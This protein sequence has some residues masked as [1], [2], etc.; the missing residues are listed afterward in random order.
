M[1]QVL[2]NLL[3]NAARYTPATRR[4]ASP[5]RNAGRARSPSPS[6][7]A[8]RACRP[9]A[10]GRL[11]DK[12]Y[13]VPRVGEGAPRHRHRPDGGARPGGGHGRL[14]RRARAARSAAWRSTWICP[15]T[16]RRKSG[17][18]PSR[19]PRARDA[20][21]A[22]DGAGCLPPKPSTGPA[23]PGQRRH[24]PS[25]LLVEDDA[26]TR[27]QVATHLR[28]H[29]Y[30][31]NEAHD[32]RAALR[33][34]GA[35]TAGPGGA[36]PRPAGPGRDARHPQASRRGGHADPDPLG[37]RPGGGQGG[38]PGAW[39]GRLP[40]EALRHGRAAGAHPGTPAARRRGP[41]CSTTGS[42][43]SAS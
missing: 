37:A 20:W 27:S 38:G 40:G 4:S 3:E 15:R 2:T 28:G 22:T 14:G 26:E 8:V 18:T 29:G 1:D 19:E 5:P 42:C 17:R 10:M 32:A 36:G 23:A 16:R 13:R 41:A 33:T 25:V 34:L 35:R 21:R 43:V 11:F 12:F 30:D 6:R 7:T 24:Q 31:V 9:E 39:R